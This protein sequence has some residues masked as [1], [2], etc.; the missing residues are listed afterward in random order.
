MKKKC[1]RC[2]IEFETNSDNFYHR[3]TSKDSWETI[4]KICNKKEKRRKNIHVDKDGNILCLVCKEYK[5]PLKFN[6]SGNNLHRNYR[7]GRCIDCKKKQAEKRKITNKGNGSIERMLLSRYLGLKERAKK[8]GL[9]VDFQKEFLLELWNKQKGY[10]AIS[11]I[12][13][14]YENFKGRVFT[15]ISVDRIDSSKGYIKENIQL[16]CMAVNQMKSDL[17]LDELLYFC[18]KIY[19]NF[20]LNYEEY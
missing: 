14:T 16:I 8:K 1:R 13:M 10:C 11:G 15:N 12:K 2:N 9:I 6:I 19:S 20:G 17:T 7:D 18:E 3:K 5:E 4:C